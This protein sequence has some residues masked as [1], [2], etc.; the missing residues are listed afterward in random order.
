MPI[1]VAVLMGGVSSEREISLRSGNAIADALLSRGHAVTRVDVQSERLRDQLD[2][3]TQDIAF[4]ALHG[5]FGEDGNV[6]RQCEAM[7]LAYT[8][9]GPASSALA[10]NKIHSK[11]AFLAAG[12]PTPA[13]E[14]L[15][16]QDPAGWERL[17][18][19]DLSVVVK[20]ALEG[21]SIGLS[22][23]HSRDALMAAVQTAFGYG[24][25]V[26]VESFVRGKELTAGILGRETLPV[27]QIVPKSGVY[28]YHSKYTAGQTEYLVPAPLEPAVA[29]Q[30]QEIAWR[31]FEALGCEDL[32]RIDFILSEEGIPYVLE[33][34]T[35]PGFT[36]TSL[37][38]KAAKAR[39]Y[40]FEDLCEKIMNMG[41][42]KGQTKKGRH[43][44]LA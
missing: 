14:V 34:N 5:R 39:G 12:L 1:R 30:V 32:G 33:A 37:L 20:P 25:D 27:I 40:S 35:I 6:Q 13:F 41:L 10:L 11:Q 9:S 2:P 4:I 16:G 17:S 21:S 18:G 29:S 36:Q 24:N 19:I 22:I 26:L 7:G 38:P 31:A 43:A 3:Q 15:N 42:V 44:I 28:D 8:G 23:V